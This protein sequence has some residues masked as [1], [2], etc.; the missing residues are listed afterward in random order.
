[1]AHLEPAGADPSTDR[2]ARRVTLHDGRVVTIR[3]VRPDDKPLF[4]EG[5]ERLSEDSRYLRFFAV[6]KA[7]SEPELTYLT[8]V[9]GTSHVA[10][11]A[12]DESG[13]GVGVARY[14]VL[15]DEPEVAE[16]AVTVLDEV[17][18]LGLG[19][20]LVE[21]LVEHARAGQVRTLRFWVLPMNVSMKHLLAA[22]GARFRGGE[23]PTQRYELDVS[24]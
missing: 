8:E 22:L 1:M 19:H 4:V 24:G 17:Q 12:L 14:V 9:D 15:E 18:G 11:G 16:V 13:R 23:G 6:K 10:L 21:H 5:F 7:L 2:D 3:P 20:R